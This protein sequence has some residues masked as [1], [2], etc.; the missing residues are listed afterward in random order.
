MILDNRTVEL[1]KAFQADM[2]EGETDLNVQL[3]STDEEELTP[4]PSDMIF[5]KGGGGT[6]S[7]NT[8]YGRLNITSTW[9]IIALFKIVDQSINNHVTP[10][11]ETGSYGD[12]VRRIQEKILQS[13][14]NSEGL[15][16]KGSEVVYGGTASLKHIYRCEIVID[17]LIEK[18]KDKPIKAMIMPNQRSKPPVPR[19]PPPPP[20]SRQQP[21][22]QSPPAKKS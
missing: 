12:R 19:Q 22:F 14:R 16:Y 7:E 15:I 6:L 13:L 18:T 17:L 20:P 1:L 2:L 21:D 4:I 5:I 8:G 9:Y 10:L 3:L 11:F